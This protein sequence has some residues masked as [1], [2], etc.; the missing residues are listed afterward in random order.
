M[1]SSAASDVYKRQQVASPFG[2]ASGGGGMFN[3]VS[4]FATVFIVVG[5]LG[6]I[7]G[8]ALALWMRKRE[9]KEH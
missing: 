6:M 7:A 9:W 4:A 8:V 2:G 3:P 1:R 5:V